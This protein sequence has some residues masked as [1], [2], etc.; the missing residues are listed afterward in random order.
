[1]LREIRIR[2][3]ALVDDLKL[4]LAPG[5]NVITGETGAGKTILFDALALLL[6]GKV[7]RSS[8]RRGSDAAIIQGLFD[9]SNIKDFPGREYAEEEGAL[10]IE[11]KIPRAGRGR[12]E[13]N[14]RL[15]PMDR[16]REWGGWLV[17]FHGQQETESLLRPA[18]QRDY[19]DTF[20]RSAGD[21]R[22]FRAALDDLRAA[23]AASG[24]EEG[25]IVSIREREDFLR[26][27]VREID[28]A[29]LVPDEEERLGAESRILREAERLRETIYFVRDSLRE[30]ERSAVDL[31]GEASERLA[32]F[33]DHGTEAPAASE[34]CERALAEIEEALASVDRLEGKI[35]V[36]PGELERILERLE[37]IASLRRKYKKPVAEILEYRD[38]AA[39]ELDLLDRSETALQE[40]REMVRGKEKVLADLAGKLSSR[41][42]RKAELLLQKVEKGIAELAFRGARFA[43][44]ISTE[45]DTEGELEFEGSRVRV[46]RSGID[47][48]E[49]LLAANRGEDLHP[50]RKVASGGE[51]SRVML[52]LKRVLADETQV[53]TALFDEIDAGVGG[54]V[55]ERI[56]EALRDVSEGRQV[57]CITHFPAIASL[58]DLHIRVEKKMLARRTVIRASR[59][60]PEERVEEVVRMM[61][62]ASRRSVSVPHAEEILR[63]GRSEQEQQGSG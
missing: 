16:L 21:I 10:L 50:L 9:I 42:A 24:E 47:Q 33:D 29:S 3:Y 31:I 49:F 36:P 25:R 38:R 57:L 22:S 20:A 44:R 62:G 48:V 35:D 39:E 11:R 5:L 18:S 23:R 52:A 32:R 63:S 17:D 7:E 37:E 51:L 27:Q 34:A 26:W 59:L 60:D 41:R 4:E 15:L 1:M 6:G 30:S 13:A 55:A 43:I 46:D 12:V 19:L 8:V 14:G 45:E 53:P 58:A 28:A 56:G 40:M 54:D 61:G 2:N